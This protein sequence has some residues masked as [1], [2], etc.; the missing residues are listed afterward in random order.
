[1]AVV[2]TVTPP[3]ARFTHA[4]R[5]V[6]ERRHRQMGCRWAVL[7]SGRLPR[8]LERLAGDEAVPWIPVRADRAGRLLA[9]AGMPQ[10]T[11]EAARES[12]LRDADRL[13]EAEREFWETAGHAPSPLRA[14]A[15]YC[16]G[17]RRVPDVV[18]RAGWYLRAARWR[19]WKPAWYRER[20]R[21]R[22]A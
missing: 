20:M 3:A 16:A 1:M 14:G 17:G 2:S 19:P 12:C 11:L 15:M 9:P 10:A 4:S 13:R 6:R 18:M 21:E 8:G 5:R 7:H 22:A